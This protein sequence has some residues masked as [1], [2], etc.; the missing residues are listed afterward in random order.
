MEISYHS[1]PLIIPPISAITNP[2]FHAIIWAHT[3]FN[4]IVQH[5]L[6]QMIIFNI[7]LTIVKI[8]DDAPFQRHVGLLRD[9]RQQP[10]ARQL[11]GPAK[12]RDLYL[13]DEG[14]ITPLWPSVSSRGL[15]Q[16]RLQPNLTRESW[17]PVTALH[18]GNTTLSFRE[19]IIPDN[20]SN[21]GATESDQLPQPWRHSAH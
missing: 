12:V 3:V 4:W 6:M 15:P 16:P 18:R 11:P 20:V 13:D 5:K 1:G 19:A 10:N 7:S 2:A 8:S 9:L 17:K 21:L 14:W